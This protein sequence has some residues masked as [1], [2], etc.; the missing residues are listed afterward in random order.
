MTVH[1]SSSSRDGSSGPD[2]ISSTLDGDADQPAG[3][4][5]PPTRW[6]RI[7]RSVGP[8]LIV[9]GSIVGSG[10]LIAT[11]K[12]GAEAGFSL[13]WLIVLGCVV[14]VFTQ[15]ELGRYAI[16]SGR[17]TLRALDEVPGP[18]I[19]GR[20][21]WLVWYWLLMWLASISQLGGIVG[22]VGQA[23]AI[24]A[25]LTQQ[26]QL[27]NEMSDAQ[28]LYQFDVY[29]ANSPREGLAKITPDELA[30][31]QDRAQRLLNVYREG[32]GSS[33]GYG[34]S[35][36]HDAAIWATVIA[37]G[38]S[39]ILFLGR[40]GLIQSLSTVLVGSFTLLTVVNLFLLQREVGWRVELAEFISGLSMHLPTA[41]N[42][43][44]GSG[45]TAGGA[46]GAGLNP[47]GTA[48]ATFGIIGV[49]AAELVVY[50]YWCLEKGYARFTGTYDGSEAWKRRAAGWMRVMHVDAWG[51]MAVYTFTTVAFYLLGAA[52]LHRVGLNPAKDD[53]VRTLA[54]MFVPVFSDWAAFVFLFGAFAVLYSTYFVANASHARVFSDA[55]R[56][57]GVISDDPVTL[58]RWVHR[59][60]GFF[61]LLCLAIYLAFPAPA[62]LVLFSGVAQG[63]MLP[64]LAAAALY[65]R[66]RRSLAALRP[67]RLWDV[68]LWI[69]AAA[70]L[71]TGTWTVVE[72]LQGYLAP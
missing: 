61:P 69:S 10:E 51:S 31:R 30:A 48:L 46:G 11:T 64:M 47:I 72:K 6:I 13:L 14:K 45:P 24:A 5:P 59:L 65:F 28:T 37:I 16:I 2:L 21:N 40:Y 57:I 20:G 56:V 22:G 1:S 33:P 17:T 35:V 68:M 54:V 49:G 44:T 4:R 38:T 26:G 19:A 29:A 36:P 18:R 23:L 42:A 34:N 53:M 3:T 7:V 50:P 8:G 58:R 39:L 12:T 27:Y 70:M 71:V 63:V 15:I 67:N 43:S 32:N 55:L 60:S 66:Y 52:V 62:Q 9:A 25:P 41:E